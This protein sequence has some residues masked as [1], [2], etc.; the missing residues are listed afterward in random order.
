M[1]FNSVAC[2][3]KARMESSRKYVFE[4]FRRRLYALKDMNV[5]EFAY[6]YNVHPRTTVSDFCSFFTLIYST[7]SWPDS[8]SSWVDLF[9]TQGQQLTGKFSTVADHHGQVAPRTVFHW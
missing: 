9:A 2:A 4:A 3:P 6:E 5:A 8:L 7:F 1:H